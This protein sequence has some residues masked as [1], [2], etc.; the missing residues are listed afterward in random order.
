MAVNMHDLYNFPGFHP[1][2]DIETLQ[3]KLAGFILQRQFAIL[4]DE[5]TARYCLPYLKETLNLQQEQLVIVP[6]GEQCKQLSTAEPVLKRMLDLN[7]GRQDLLIN[8][9]GGTITDLGGFCAAVYKRGIGFIHIPTTLLAM[10]DAA[11]GGKTGINFGGYK[12]MLGTFTRAEALLVWPGMLN[13][14]PTEEMRNGWAETVKH[15]LILDVELWDEVAIMEKLETPS[16]EMIF[17]SATLKQRVIQ[18]DFHESGYRKILNFGH[19]AA[20]AIESVLAAQKQSN[21][22]GLAVAAGMVIES[23][24]CSQRGLLSPGNLDGIC[25]VIRRHFP[26]A[27]PEADADHMLLAAMKMDKKSRGRQ[28]WIAGIRRPGEGMPEIPASEEELLDALQFYRNL[29][30]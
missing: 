4:A 23:H 6:P 22:H 16:R 11:I 8:L 28:I 20:H 2:P 12:N 14:L 1:C 24:V 10:V 9:G 21:S 17:R 27:C 18:K 5:N 7:L 30:G 25:R 26:P 15:A 29:Y 19:T 3:Q 13:T